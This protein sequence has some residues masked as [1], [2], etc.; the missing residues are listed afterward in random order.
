M[1]NKLIET[2]FFLSMLGG[3]E[4]QERSYRGVTAQDCWPTTPNIVGCYMLRPFPHP[5]ACCWMLLRVVA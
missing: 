5:V 3:Y 1:D 2:L 4:E